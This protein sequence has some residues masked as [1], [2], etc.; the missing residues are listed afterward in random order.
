[1]LRRL[2][3]QLGETM[4]ETLVSILI[5]A[6]AMTVLATVIG[7][8][9]NIVMKS[10]DHMNEFY[11]AESDMIASESSVQQKISVE[12]PLEAGQDQIAVDTYSAGDNTDIVYYKQHSG[13]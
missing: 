6:L 13:V 10:K 9:V 3:C 1:M 11:E 7:T 8:S 12:V 2:K 4:V 5:S